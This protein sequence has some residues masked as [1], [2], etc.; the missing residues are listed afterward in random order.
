MR[1]KVLFFTVA[2]FIGG[3]SIGGA[4]APLA[5]AY[6]NCA[7]A[8]AAGAAPLYRG[9]PG[10]S[11]KLDRD[12]DGVACETGSS[13]RP[14]GQPVP[15]PLI[16]SPAVP[17]P[18]STPIPAPT[19]QPNGS[20]GAYETVVNWTGTDCIDITAP[21]SSPARVL[22]TSNHCGGTAR[23][24]QEASDSQMVGADPIMGDAESITCEILTG[25]LRDSG[26][27]GDGHD[28]NCLTRADSLK[29]SA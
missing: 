11:A 15:A 24:S 2:A 21:D 18:V 1:I 20:G 16:P 27:R 19:A 6:P 10:Y 26:T 3:P 8:R 14:P 28:V 17:Q 7:A 9:Q 12:G 13:G 29:A 4:V 25:R 22:A 5:H 23:F